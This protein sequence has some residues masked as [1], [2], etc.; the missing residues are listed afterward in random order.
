MLGII[1]IVLTLMPS[2]AGDI[3]T[4]INVSADNPFYN[5]TQAAPTKA[6]SSFNLLWVA[7]LVAV[8]V[9]IIAG[10]AGLAFM[11]MRK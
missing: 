5:L 8:V 7:V 1:A 10:V 2:I 4:A 9:I 11:F 6:T 3:M